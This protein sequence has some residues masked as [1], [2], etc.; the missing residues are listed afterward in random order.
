M[1]QGRK[2]GGVRREGRFHAEGK[3]WH[4]LRRGGCGDDEGRRKQGGAEVRR[5]LIGA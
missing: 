3:G 4:A 1:R 5:G 2:N